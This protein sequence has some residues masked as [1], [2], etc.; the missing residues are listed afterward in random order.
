MNAKELL[1]ERIARLK[2]CATINIDYHENNPSALDE[3]EV[4][5]L[6][7]KTSPTGSLLDFYKSLNGAKLLCYS[8]DSRR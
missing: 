5:P 6:L 1:E 3:F 2:R 4:L 7:N 8:R